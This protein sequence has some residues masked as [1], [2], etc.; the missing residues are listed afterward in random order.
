[1][2]IK[3][4]EYSYDY[5]R[6]LTQNHYENF[7]VGSILI[8]KTIRK[9]IYPIYAFARTADDIADSSN[10]DSEEK[11]SQLNSMEAEIDKID[12]KDTDFIDLY[13]NIFLSLSDTIQRFKIPKQEFINLLN[14]FK[15]DSIKNRYDHFNDLIEYSGL[16][17]N[18][19][20]HLILYLFGNSPEKNKEMFVYSDKI[21]TAL[22]LTNFWQ[23]VKSDLEINRIYIPKTIMKEFNYSEDDLHNLKEDNNFILLM[24]NLIQKT[25]ILFKEGLPLIELLKGRLKLELKAIINGGLEILNKIRQVEYRVLSKKVKLN[26]LDKIKILGKSTL[27]NKVGI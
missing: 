14:A 25:E 20:G 8:P 26:N 9:Y 21:C 7:P 2:E 6:N 23:D 1:L 12:N 19:V 5:C 15:Q 27:N 24:K 13:K 10:L 17:A 4:L 16:S 18:P 22:Q 11:L 3:S